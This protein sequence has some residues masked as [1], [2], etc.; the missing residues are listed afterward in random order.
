VA[1]QPDLREKLIQ[2]RLDAVRPAPLK[3]HPQDARILVRVLDL[4][5]PTFAL[6]SPVN[7][8]SS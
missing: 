4:V 7:P 5:F 1:R 2:L 8:C 6:L 3:E